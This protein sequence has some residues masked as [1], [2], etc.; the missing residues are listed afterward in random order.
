MRVVLPLLVIGG[1]AFFL[2]NYHWE[3]PA[4]VRVTT[5]VPGA[6]IL[7][8]GTQTGYQSDTTLPV[9]P[10]RRIITVR[11]PNYISDPE[12]V[13]LDITRRPG[14]AAAFVLKDASKVMQR[15]SIPPLRPVRQQIFSTGQPVRSVPPTYSRSAHRLI[16]YSSKDSKTPSSAPA[17]TYDSPSSTIVGDPA[18]SQPLSSTQITVTSVPDQ[19][20]IW[21]NGASASHAT[22]YTFRGLD[23]GDYVFR[24]RKDGFVAN[25]DSIVVSLAEDYQSEL[26]S[27]ALLQDPNAPRPALTVTTEPLAA[28]IRIDGHPV[29]IGSVTIEPGFGA[30]KIEFNDVPGYKTPGSLTVS[31]TA[32]EPH[33]SATGHYEKLIGNSYLAVVPSEDIERF[34]G[35]QLRVFVDNELVMDGS[36]QKFGAVL[37]SRIVAGRHLVR[38]QYGDIMSDLNATLTDDQVSEL[39]FRIESFFSKRKLAIKENNQLSLDP[40]KQKFRKTGVLSVS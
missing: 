28:G 27:F 6:E 18:S 3:R 1:A 5:T 20:D 14:Y 38:I 19:A 21:V 37:L 26:A 7:V 24:V 35:K 33:G 29:G 40:W 2:L 17:T 13:V 23:R 15:D 22:P 39:T 31:L 9:E 4:M 36:K 12:F 34:D 25:P 8:D 11:K 16:D 30:H 32:T 10:G